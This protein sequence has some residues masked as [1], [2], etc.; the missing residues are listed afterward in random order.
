MVWTV[1]ARIDGQDTTGEIWYSAGQKWAIQNG[2]SDGTNPEGNITREQLAAM[3]Y[4]YAQLKGYDT[5]KAA[6]LS[7]YTDAKDLSAY[8]VTSMQWAVEEGIINGMTETMIVPNG[9]AT[10]AQT[11]MMLMNFFESVNK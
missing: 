10:R 2:I 11:A 9:N 7:K 8:A 5:T 3:L 1:L 6:D 4:R